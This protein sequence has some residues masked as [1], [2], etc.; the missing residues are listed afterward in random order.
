MGRMTHK[1]YPM[2]V[3][4]DAWALVAP[5]CTLMTAE[6][7]QRDHRLREV[8]NGLRWIVRAEAAWRLRPQD[9]PP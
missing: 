2:D 5:Y 7:P 4:D 6:D 3:R 1:A 9:R 8:C